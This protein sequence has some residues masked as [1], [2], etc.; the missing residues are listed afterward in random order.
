MSH[1]RDTLGVDFKAQSE[2]K[3]NF[4][5]IKFGKNIPHSI[6][7]KGNVSLKLNKREY[8]H[9]L[10]LMILEE[11]SEGDHEICPSCKD[12]GYLE[13]CTDGENGEEWEI[14]ACEECGY[15]G[16]GSVGDWT[17]ANK[18]ARDMHKLEKKAKLI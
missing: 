15:F 9:L 17:N 14:Q 7:K 13:V 11:D 16:E 12:L 10:A 4:Y 5:K 3:N 8:F 2:P 18:N 1:I 6:D